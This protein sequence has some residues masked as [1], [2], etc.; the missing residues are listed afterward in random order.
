MTRF[1][2]RGSLNNVSLKWQLMVI[3]T[4]LVAIP[5]VGMGLA[6]YNQSVASSDERTGEEVQELA[7]LATRSINPIY[8]ILQDDVNRGS[9]TVQS[10]IT[11]TGA[12]A[13]D[14]ND[15]LTVAAINQDDQSSTTLAV[16]S[17]KIGGTKVAGN[18]R[19]VD[20]VQ[21]SSGAAATIFELI[22]QGLLR[23]STNVIKTDGS[24]AVNTYIPVTSPVYQAIAAGQTY[25]GVAT[26]LGKP[27]LASYQPL[28]DATGKVVG[29]VFAGMDQAPYVKRIT[30]ELVKVVIGKSG[31]IFILSDTGNYV[32]SS[33]NKRDGENIWASKDANGNLF[34]Q[35]MIA[36]AKSLKDG[37]TG[38]I[39]YAWKN[40]GE[41]TARNKISGFTYFAPFNWTIG[42]GAYKDD[43]AGQITQIRTTTVWTCLVAILLGVLVSFFFAQFIVGSFRELVGRMQQVAKGDLTVDLGDQAG[44]SEI[45]Q[46]AQ[47]FRVMVENIKN[48]ITSINTNAMTISAAAQQLAASTQQVNAATQQ[49]TSAVQEVAAGSES[50]AKQTEEVSHNAG[51]LTEESRKGAMAAGEAGEKMKTL[52]ST[53]D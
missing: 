50:L 27:Y 35:N 44:K 5:T 47:A 22:P 40:T 6:V 43:F 29:A 15:P 49:I 30:N 42:A 48:L 16:P 38:V 13:L 11:A 18:Y 36:S 19:I 39:T 34:I 31:Y 33:G 51:S 41:T 9:S 20:Q 23:V 14:A 2:V 7:K 45:G 21:A 26:V 52:A 1:N 37:G 17:L 4:I 24:R 8:N 12:V 53:V 10:L 3:C 25:Q 46:M 28:K 32:L